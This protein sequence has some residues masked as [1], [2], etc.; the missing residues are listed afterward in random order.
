MI[1][2]PRDHQFAARVNPL[3]DYTCIVAAHKQDLVTRIDHLAMLNQGVLT[4]LM[5]HHRSTIN[6]GCHCY[7]SQSFTG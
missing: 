2:E 5:G 3:I 1:N 4:A 7:H 6:Q